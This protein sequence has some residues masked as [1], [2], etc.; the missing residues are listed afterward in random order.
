MPR[1]LDRRVEALAPVDDPRLA[2]R[3][4]EVLEVGRNDDLLAWDLGPDSVWRRAT[5]RTGVETHA[6]L[7][8]R[9]RRRSERPTL[10]G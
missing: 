9:A 10:R 7:Q 6:T 2:A 5:A 3:L 1:N 8:E 4:D